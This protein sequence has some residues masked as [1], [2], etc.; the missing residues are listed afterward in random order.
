MLMSF[1]RR[2]TAKVNRFFDRFVGRRRLKAAAGQRPLNIVVGASGVSDS[3]WTRTDA[4]FLN[5]L[6]PD[7]WQE[8]FGD[9]RID[10]ILAEHVWEHLTPS[11][12]VVAAETCFKFLRSGGQLRVAVPDGNN[13]SAEY[14]DWVRPGGTGPGAHDHKALY[15][16]ET[17]SAVFRQAGFLVEPLEWF[18]SAG[19]FHYVDWD[20]AAGRITRSRRY[21]QRNREGRLGYTS[22]IVD[23]RKP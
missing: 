22:L 1:K 11:D 23:A 5:L 17:F 9:A 3:G 19:K 6:N 15:T 4:E 21:D 2:L 14:R 16:I 8:I 12:A 18:D 13:P 10:R 7:Q 20:P